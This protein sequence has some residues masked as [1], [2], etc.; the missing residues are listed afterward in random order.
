MTLL[1]SCRPAVWPQACYGGSLCRLPVCE[2]GVDRAGRCGAVFVRSRGQQWAGFIQGARGARSWHGA[3]PALTTGPCAPPSMGPLARDAGLS[4]PTGLSA[5]CQGAAFPE[6]GPGRADRSATRGLLPATPNRRRGAWGSASTGREVKAAAGGPCGPRGPGSAEALDGLPGPE[7]GWSLQPAAQ[8]CPPHGCRVTWFLPGPHPGLSFPLPP[9][10]SG[11]S[12]SWTLSCFE[13]QC[14]YFQKLRCSQEGEHLREQQTGECLLVPPGPRP[15]NP[16]GVTSPGAA[17][18]SPLPTGGRG[19]ASP[20]GATPLPEQPL[21]L[22]PGLPGPSSWTLLPTRSRARGSGPGRAP[23]VLGRPALRL[24]ASSAA[25]PSHREPLWASLSFS[26]A[27]RAPDCP[28]MPSVPARAHHAPL[29]A[30]PGAAPT[31][32]G[33]REFKHN[34]IDVK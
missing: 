34:L 22:K 4:G 10:S 12:L 27:Q 11:P 21:I 17:S 7:R 23:G 1:W 16:R 18:G 33:R 9:G 29:R 28:L 13:H 25:W 19:R 30:R 20:R 32:C 6:R 31:Q 14:S 2:G 24:M 15:R 3:R 8:P 5:A 26:A